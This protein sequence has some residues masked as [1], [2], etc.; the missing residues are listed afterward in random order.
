MAFSRQK[1]SLSRSEQIRQKRQVESVKRETTARQQTYRATH[2]QTVVARNYSQAVP[3]YQSAAIKSRKSHYYNLR[4]SGAEVHV[5]ALSNIKINAK[6]LSGFVALGAFV[7][8]M[9]MAVS[10]SFKIK[11]L[12]LR[13][14]QRVTALDLQTSLDLTNT[15]M[16]SI[17]PI[18]TIAQIKDAYPELSNIR[19]KLV[20][21][22]KLIISSTERVPIISW[23]SD[24]GTYWMDVEGVIFPARG[25]VLPPLTI[26]AD[27]NPPVPNALA[28]SSNLP[29]AIS[30]FPR[31]L[32]PVILN[33]ILQLSASMPQEGSFL[34]SHEDGLG[35]T[36]SRGW[37]VYVGM[38]L[39]DLGTKISEYNAIIK[40]L[41]QQGIRPVM[42]SVE[43]MDAPFFRT[44]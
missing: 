8:I 43:H 24:K 39:T 11:S 33:A 31:Q 35:W 44:E 14:A 15:S 12:E 5:R 38:D 25:D 6:T 13:G 17:D 22:S 21:P 23:A 9:F 29:G 27:E 40:Q 19:L 42:V 32:D 2:P 7:L 37:K 41:D 30:T 1:S 10:S 34:Y 3:L 4:N 36:D 28:Q 16:I 20:M 26:Q 18:K